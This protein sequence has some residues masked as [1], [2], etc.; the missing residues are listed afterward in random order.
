M[1][2]PAVAE[3]DDRPNARDAAPCRARSRGRDGRAGGGGERGA[4]VDLRG[5]ARAAV[6]RSHAGGRA[7]HPGRTR[8]SGRAAPADRSDGLTPQ[9]AAWLAGATL[10]AI[11]AA[12]LAPG[13]TFW[14]A[15]ELIAAVHALGIPHPPGTPLYIALAHSWSSALGVVF[16]Y[17]RATNLLSAVCTAAAGAGSAWLLARRSRSPDSGWIGMTGAVAAGTMMSVWSNAT[18]TEVYSVALL[19]AVALLIAGARAGEGTSRRHER[20]LLLTVYL[21]VLA[22]A[23]HLSVLVAAP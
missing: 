19:H 16:G 4:L 1:H 18:E 5:G 7:G 15:G 9:R 3:V 13:V 22:P 17:A 11:Y 8:A 21:M 14:D 12:T 2:P 10:L 6:A 23:V 20:W